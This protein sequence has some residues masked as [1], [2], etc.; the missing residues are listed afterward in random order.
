MTYIYFWGLPPFSSI[1]YIYVFFFGWSYQL[2]TKTI[3]FFYVLF[4]VVT[5]FYHINYIM[6]SIFIQW[7]FVLFFFLI[8]YIIVFV[9][10]AAFIHVF[11]FWYMIK[12]FFEYD[13]DIFSVLFTNREYNSGNFYTTPYFCLQIV[14]NLQNTKCTKYKIFRRLQ[15]TK[16][17]IYFLY[18]QNFVFGTLQ[19]SF[20]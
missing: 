14:N 1:L 3:I 11:I 10:F 20:I 5:P 13:Q 19:M 8:L 9:S 12:I 18:W 16:Y 15:N 6:I 17:K 7:Y 4:F 2:T